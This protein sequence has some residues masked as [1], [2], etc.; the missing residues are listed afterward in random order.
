MDD[1]EWTVSADQRTLTLFAAVHDVAKGND[2]TRNGIYV[3]RA[4]YPL[5]PKS[6]VGFRI[7]IIAANTQAE[8]DQLVDVLGRLAQRFELQP[9]GSAEVAA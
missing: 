3:T 2:G 5:V 4:A 1:L 7:Q 6:E 9:A 8:I